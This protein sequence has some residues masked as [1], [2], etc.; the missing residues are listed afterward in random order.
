[1]FGLFGLLSTMSMLGRTQ[2]L[3]I[4][5]PEALGPILKFYLSYWGE[6]DGFATVFHPLK[7][8]APETILETKSIEVQAFP[9]NHGIETFG[10]LFREKRPQLNVD[11]EML[12]R[13]RFA[14]TEIG[15][16]KAGGDVVRDGVTSKG[17]STRL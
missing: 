17:A 10:F 1:M 4:Y 9:L 6:E 15:T 8:K 12:A 5:G 11:K 16:L 2:D 14:L 3:H 13:Y 7:M